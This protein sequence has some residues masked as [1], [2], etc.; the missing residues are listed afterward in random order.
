[1]DIESQIGIRAEFQFRQWLNF[2]GQNNSIFSFSA[3]VCQIVL[4]NS[5]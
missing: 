4:N 2:L 3:I 1:M 5:I